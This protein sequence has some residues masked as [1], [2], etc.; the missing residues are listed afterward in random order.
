MTK[1]RQTKSGM[2]G[3]SVV[4]TLFIWTLD[5]DMYGLGVFRDEEDA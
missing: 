3:K 4:A 1:W 2:R 5:M